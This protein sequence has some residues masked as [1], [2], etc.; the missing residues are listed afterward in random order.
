MFG[1]VPSLIFISVIALA[2]G[3]REKAAF[4][5]A[6]FGGLLLDI[7]SVGI[8]F[9]TLLLVVVCALTI[10]FKDKFVGESKELAYG[11]V[12][13]WSA[14]ALV[15]EA[16]VLYYFFGLAVNLYY[17]GLKIVLT[18][19]YNLAALAVLFPL[20]ERLPHDQ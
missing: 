2:A 7:F 8:Y 12:A 4:G 10:F 11:F 16:A 19:L 20:L 6:L 18:V 13:G 14:A 9:Q 1:A 15:L 5:S 17:A 3:N